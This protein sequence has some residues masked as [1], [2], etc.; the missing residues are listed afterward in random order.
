MRTLPFL[1]AILCLSAGP[2][3]AEDRQPTSQ[4][5]AAIRI[6]C[7]P[8]SILYGDMIMQAL[9]GETRVLEGIKKIQPSFQLQSPVADVAR[10]SFVPGFDVALPG[11]LVQNL[12]VDSYDPQIDAKKLL[13][14]LAKM[15]EQ[16]LASFDAQYQLDMKFAAEE[17]RHC[18]RLAA[19]LSRRKEEFANLC[20]KL[21]VDPDPAVTAQKRLQLESENQR[22]TVEIQGLEARGGIIEQQIAKYAEQV[23]KPDEPDAAILSELRKSVDAHRKIVQARLAAFQTASP[24]GSVA[25]L[26]HA[27]DDLAKAEAELAKQRRA[28]IAESGGK[29]IDVLRERLEDATIELQ[30]LEGKKRAVFHLHEKVPRS[31]PQVDMARIHLELLQEDYRERSAELNKLA[32]KIQRHIPPNVEII[33]V[34]PAPERPDAAPAK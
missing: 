17:R 25:D 8:K 5:S 27:K 13:E 1:A 24:G 32:G 10:V 16:D 29:R 12:R 28:I 19:D 11:V 22:L 9:A 15:L 31:A 3:I 26:E 21:G 30:E 2:A 20:A 7:D 6:T 14:Q 23:E 33:T 34:E 18:E 4:V